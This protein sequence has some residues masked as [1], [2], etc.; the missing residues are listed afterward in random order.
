MRTEI[1]EPL[2]LDMAVEPNA[3]IPGKA[4][5]YRGSSGRYQ[6]VDHQWEQ[7]RDGAIQTTPAE[8]ARWG[9]NYPRARSAEP[10]GR[11]RSSLTP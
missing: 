4:V 3:L 9:D 11:L 10:T 8:L 2:D 7:V 6:V 1:S 5:S